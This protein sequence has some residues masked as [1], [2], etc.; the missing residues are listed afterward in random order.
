M[1]LPFKICHS[2][3]DLDEKKWNLKLNKDHAFLNSSFLEIFENS[4]NSDNIVP[5][6]ISFNNGIIYGHLIKIKGNKV[7]NYLKGGRLSIKK[8]LIKTFNFQFFC[9]GNTHFSNL[10]SNYFEKEKIKEI[11]LKLLLKHLKKKYKINF[12]LLPD[13]FLNSIVNGSFKG[14]S[15]LFEIDPD[16]VLTVNSQWNSFQD[17]CDA[18]HSKYKKRVRKVLKDSGSLT[19]KKLN[20]QNIKTLIPKLQ[21]L[22]NNVHQKSTFS[23]PPLNL[24][25]YLSFA[26][27]SDIEFSLYGYYN[28]EEIIAFSSEFYKEEKLYSYFIGLNYSFN[29]KYSLYNRILYD[30]IKNGIDKKV[31]K[32]VYG[33]TAAE[34]K[35]NIGAV[36]LRS[37]SAIYISNKFLRLLLYPIVDNLYPK[38]WILRNP[39]KVRMNG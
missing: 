29:K 2:I 36:P 15:P 30:S 19:I 18:I 16:M 23:G 9:F 20:P 24:N 37:Q 28:N 13:H 39:F 26:E 8:Q 3:I 5:F 4:Y 7:A 27:Y 38:K 22:Y 31:S 17:Y 32:I 14:V 10:P 35:S 12:F 34:F 11:D 6:Y 1:S 33:R 25:T 21:N